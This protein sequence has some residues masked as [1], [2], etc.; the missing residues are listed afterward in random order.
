MQGL[1]AAHLPPPH[2]LVARI[3]MG[4]PM[5]APSGLM[6]AWVAMNPVSNVPE[7]GSTPPSPVTTCPPGLTVLYDGSCPLCRREISVYRGA[8]AS[9]PLSFSDV[10]NPALV[11]PAG[12]RVEALMARFHVQHADGRLESGARAFIALWALLPGWRWLA[13]LGRLPGMTPLM[14]WAYRGFLRVRP[15]FQALARRWDRQPAAAGASAL[16]HEL[17][18]ELRTDHAGETGAV[19]I[20]RGVLAA[21]RDPALRAFAEHHLDTE[22][23]HLTQIEQLIP[24]R[25][26]SRLLPLWRVSGWLTG[27]LPACAGPRAVY[28][29]IQA[30]ETFVDR[31]YADQVRLIDTLLSARPGVEPSEPRAAMARE[32]QNLRAVLEQCRLDEVS[33]R[34][35]A[36]HRWDGH[37]SAWLRLWQGMVGRGSAW[38][39]ALCRRL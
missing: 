9:Q 20:Y 21:T 32:L 7:E 8:Q 24:E 3:G 18:R 17:L 26:R 35:D 29:T 36:A 39:V 13:R 14:E 16:P 2:A 6:A 34:D 11:P 31:H 25:E 28:A 19:M 4:A 10:S 23:R 22:R 12:T 30:V 15:A 38:A 1:G 37:A 33:H 5:H 27:A